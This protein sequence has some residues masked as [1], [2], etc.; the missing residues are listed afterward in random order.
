MNFLIAIVLLGL[1]SFGSAEIPHDFHMSYCQAELSGKVLTG[2]ISYFKDDFYL[3]LKNW[4][5]S[6]LTGLPKEEFDKI[7]VGYLGATLRVTVNGSQPLP[8]KV[9]SREEDGGSVLVQFQFTSSIEIKSLVIENSVL[10]KEFKD[11]SN[12]MLMKYGRKEVNQIFDN[13]T[14]TMTIKL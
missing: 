4:K 12:L 9:T 1:M 6:D 8:L 3:A 11:Q 7:V 13:S 2:K 14:R 5:G 10:L